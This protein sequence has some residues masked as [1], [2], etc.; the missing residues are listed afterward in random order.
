MLVSLQDIEKIIP[1]ARN[2]RKND[3][4]IEKVA[5]SIKEFGW[6]Q[7]IVV[8]TEGVIIAG[9]TRYQ[10]AKRL[11]MTD[12]PVHI[13]DGLTDAQ[14]KAYRLADNRSGQEAEWDL[15]LLAIELGDLKDYDLSLT[16]FDDEEIDKYLALCE[17]GEGLTDENE[18]P[19]TPE[20]P[21]TQL[22]DIWI[23]GKHRLVCGDCTDADVVV[24]CLNGVEPHLMVTDPP[25][26][27]EYDPEWRDKSLDA[28][29]K[30]TSVGR[31]DND[32]RCDWSEAYALFPGDVCYVWHPPGALQMQF[33]QSL[34]NCGFDVRMQIIW[35]KPHFPIGRGNYH[36]QHEP[37]W[38]AVRKKT[39]S[40][41]HWQGDRTQSTVWKI[42]NFSA[43]GS[44]KPEK[45]NERTGH[46]TQKPVECMRRPIENNSSPGQAV[47]E[48]FSGSGT[49]IIA[50]EQT[51]RACHA[52]EI[53]PVYVDV[54]V[55]RWMDYTGKYAILESTGQKYGEVA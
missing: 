22:G 44:K 28:W 2:P 18:V 27:V 53:N 50:A 48:P 32:G 45:E 16:G 42:D 52:I 4:A 31:V 30:P 20:V 39:G 6:R 33:Y 8:D 23:L 13:A 3:D 11:G 19:E 5:A 10:A 47:Y 1:Y 40:T 21:I 54:A 9:H 24:A 25:Y 17:V 12:C 51:G 35:A 46:G 26:G 49:T 15:D 38:Y 7:P 36:V 55:K 43:F 29:G 37:C 14:I 41:A 34:T